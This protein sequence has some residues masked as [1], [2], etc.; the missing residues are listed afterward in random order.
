MQAGRDCQALPPLGP[1]AWSM[2]GREGFCFTL[3]ATSIVFKEEGNK[4]K[5]ITKDLSPQIL[6]LL[7]AQSFKMLLVEKV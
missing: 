7:E 2:A 1:R 5:K 3:F 6:T 4:K